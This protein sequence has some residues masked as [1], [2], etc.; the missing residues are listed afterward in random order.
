VSLH[1]VAD[2]FA[3]ARADGVD[4]LDAQLMLSACMQQSRTWLIANGDATLPAAASN[5]FLSWLR[6]RATGEPLA[7]ILGEKEFH[8][9]LLKVNRHV[10]VPRPDTETLV[11]WALEAMRDASAPK[12]VDLG[13]GSGAIALAVKQSHPAAK[14]TATDASD[15][16]LAVARDNGQRLGL[17][18]TWKLGS[19]WKP[20]AGQR[21]DIALSNPPYIN[22]DDHHLAALVHEPRSA[23]TAGADGL[24]DIRVIVSGAREHLV[25]GGWLMLEHGHDQASS[26][27]GLLADAGFVDIA[28]RR[29]LAG[30]ERCT[31]ARTP[32]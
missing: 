18:V 8:G 17:S 6:R 22:E 13:T 9:L 31:G 23:L 14:V 15:E 12:V 10:L 32:H 20:L 19:W 30:I 7:Y 16:A 24:D 26:V 28:S 2:A 29:D 3:Q 25:P 1:T 21:F 5:T 27:A 4:R 11:D